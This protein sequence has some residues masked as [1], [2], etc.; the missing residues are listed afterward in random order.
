MEINVSQLLQEP[1]GATRDYRVDEHA[2]IIGDGQAYP[3]RGECRL[4]RTR[5]GVLVSCSLGAELELTCSRCLSRFRHPLKIKFEEEFLPTIDVTSGV[6]LP[7]Q[8]DAAFMIDDHH[9]LDLMDAVREYALMAVPMKPLCKTSCAGLCPTCGANLN[10]GSC[11][12][13]AQA[14]D[15]RWSQLSKLR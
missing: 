4:L 14:T 5:R 1:I 9:T 2:D 11:G 10:N 13:P 6:P 12:C 3:L 8:E 7:Q 15:P